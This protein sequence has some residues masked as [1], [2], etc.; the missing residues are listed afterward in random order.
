LQEAWRKV[1]EKCGSLSNGIKAMY[2]CVVEQVE[3]LVGPL[4]LLETEAIRKALGGHC[5]VNWCFDILGLGYPDWP[6][7]DPSGGE[8]G[9]KRKQGMAGGK[10]VGTS[11][12]GRR[13]RRRGSSVER[14]VVAKVLA[15]IATVLRPRPMAPV[16]TRSGAAG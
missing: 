8:V 4:M 5:R 12:R 9:G 13:G 2:E 6:T 7:M 1:I 15:S 11:K 14:S 3:D 16:M 10:E